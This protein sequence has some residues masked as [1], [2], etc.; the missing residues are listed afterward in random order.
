MSQGASFKNYSDAFSTITHHKTVIPAVALAKEEIELRGPSAKEQLPK[1]PQKQSR[2]IGDLMRKVNG[3]FFL[4]CPCGLNLK[5]PPNFKAD[6]VTCP[7][8]KR[9]L[10]LPQS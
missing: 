10:Q 7:R 1:T 6:T 5:V 3:F 9:N 8:C 4:S 2:Q